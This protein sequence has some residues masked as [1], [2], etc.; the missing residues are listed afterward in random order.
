MAQGLRRDLIEAVVQLGIER[1]ATRGD[2]AKDQS[3]D[4]IRDQN[5]RPE[6]QHF[7]EVAQRF[8]REQRQN[9]RER[10]FREELLP[11]ENND[12]EP[13]AVAERRDERPP[14]SIRQMVMQN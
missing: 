3:A 11:A 2:P 13:D 5:D 14:R 6:M 12:E 9:H 7:D 1:A 4:Q 10:V 8:A